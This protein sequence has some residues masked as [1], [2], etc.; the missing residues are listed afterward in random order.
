MARYWQTLIT[1]TILTEGDAPPTFDTLAHV[2]EA[3][4][5]GDASGEWNQQDTEVPEQTMRELLLAQGS[6]ATFLIG[7]AGE[8]I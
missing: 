1:A 2:H 4:T 8:A 3:I 5:D 6:E 7:E